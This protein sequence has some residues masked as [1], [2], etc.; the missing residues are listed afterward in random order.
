LLLFWHKEA[1]YIKIQFL[2]L[3]KCRSKL[4]YYNFSTTETITGIHSYQRSE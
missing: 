3:K 4:I 2:G 1:Y